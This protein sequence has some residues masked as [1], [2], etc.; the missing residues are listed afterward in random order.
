M[1]PSRS[2]RGIPVDKAYFH[3]TC[4]RRELFCVYQEHRQGAL[5]GKQEIK[6]HYNQTWIISTSRKTGK[7]TEFIDTTE[8]IYLCN[9]GLGEGTVLSTHRRMYIW[10]LNDTE[11]N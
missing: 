10:Q 8:L 11:P 9:Y 4:Q 1:L 5:K 7:Y 3:D 2:A 6:Y